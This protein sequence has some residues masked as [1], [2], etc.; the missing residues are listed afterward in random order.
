MMPLF[1]TLAGLAMAQDPETVTPEGDAA[2][3]EAAPPEHAVPEAEDAPV[4]DAESDD[5][6]DEPEVIE[7]S[8]V[9]EPVE[10]D[11]R[12]LT[13]GVDV[14][15]QFTG[16]RNYALFSGERYMLGLGARAQ[17]AVHDRVQLLATWQH[18]QRGAS[19][20]VFNSDVEDIEHEVHSALTVDQFGL[21]ARADVGA[22]DQVL[23]PY[24]LGQV[25]LWRGMVRLDDDPDTATNANQLRKSGFAAGIVMMAGVEIRVPEQGFAFYGELGHHWIDRA[26]FGDLGTIRPRGFIHRLGIAYRL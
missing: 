22:Y 11:E 18:S 15:H 3:E 20:R 1:W 19:I 7:I 13:F 16:Q 17:V 2:I 10:T 14:A 21:G 9:E 26:S 25:M 6:A 4:V 5:D 23:F 8:D 12:W 24:A